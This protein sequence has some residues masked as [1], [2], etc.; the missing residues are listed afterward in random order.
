MDA[1][2]LV[3]KLQAISSKSADYTSMHFQL[4]MG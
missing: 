4:V 3:V 1:G 2:D